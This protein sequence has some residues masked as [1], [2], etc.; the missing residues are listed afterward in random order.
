M[1]DIPGDAWRLVDWKNDPLERTD[2]SDRESETFSVLK[3]LALQ[4][5]AW[6]REHERGVRNAKR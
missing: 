1:F 2:L 6:L 4:K 3:Y 5:L